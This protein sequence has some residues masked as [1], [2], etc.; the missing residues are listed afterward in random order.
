[1]WRT[2][3]GVLRQ[4]HR[5]RPFDVLHAFWATE[6]GLLTTI[7]GRR[8]GIPTLVSLAGGELVSLPAI[9]YGDQRI[10]WERLKVATT[11]RL[12]SA[13]TA[14]S[15]QLRA[16]AE[17]HTRAQRLYYA[18]LG[19]PLDMF[20]PCAAHV[21]ESRFLHVG[22]LT[23]VKDQA[24]L[25]RAFARLPAG[26]RLDIVGDGPLRAG[27]EHMANTLG[28]AKAVTFHANIDHAA[29]PRVYRQATAF[30]VSSLHEAQSMV[31]IEAAAC[32]LHVVGTRVGVIPELS[33]AVAPTGNADALARAMAASLENRS[34]DIARKHFGVDQCTRRFR[35][36][37]GC[38]K[39]KA[40]PRLTSDF[41]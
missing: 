10:A 7:A 37:Y 39:D 40:R 28:V 36:L 30:V 23:P 29:L 3:L 26:A 12:A 21:D 8:L 35:D 5:R 24:S 25:L 38:L 14:G 16:L 1:V 6:S 18:P 9:Q 27:L 17:K 31:A 4:E 33:D 20:S 2:T 34:T 11:L 22:A 32:G 13:V 41:R 19:V 15:Y